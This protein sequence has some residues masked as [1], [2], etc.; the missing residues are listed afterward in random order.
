VLLAAEA[1]ADD[2]ERDGST[3]QV[4]VPPEELRAV[5]EGLEAAGYGVESAELSLIPK[6]TVGISDEAAA[7]KVVRLIE[8]L[9]EAD[10]VQ[11]VY[12]NFDISEAILESVV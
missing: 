5:R 12:A 9:E 8:G 6:S 2:V 3:Y 11:D 10:D 7:R 1:G 4:T